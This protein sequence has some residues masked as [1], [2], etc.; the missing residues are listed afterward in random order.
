LAPKWEHRY[1]IEVMNTRKRVGVLGATGSVGQRMVQLLDGHPLFE[2]VAVAASER[3]VGQ[4]FGDA[5]SWRLPSPI[6]EDAAALTVVAC[7]PDL[8]CDLIFSALD[9]SVA[10]PIEE[11]FA[12]TGY[13]VISNAS[14]HRFG[15]HVP[16]V[17][18]EV[19]AEQLS[20]V[21]KQPW[22]GGIITNPNCV[23]IGLAL[24]LKPLV[25]F[26]LEKVHVTTLQAASGAGYPGVPS[27]DLIDN[28]VP[29]I[30]GEAEKIERELPKVL[31]YSPVISAQ[32]H[33]VPVR[34]G[35]LMSVSVELRTASLADL[36]RAWSEFPG[37]EAPLA[38]K[39]PIHVLE[40]I[41]APQPMLHRD[42]EGGMAIAV[43]QVRECPV[44]THRFSVL[45]H[46]T[47][48]GAAGGTL[49]LGALATRFAPSFERL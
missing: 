39:H 3:S 1:S 19:N 35:H 43:G 9:A 18:P 2:L 6:P 5:V 27:M 22:E 24:A 40:G 8:D 13:L 12:R 46:N 36:K 49:L 37:V 16:L 38:P 45:S 17:V 34:E 20:W 7:N 10:G 11:A 47:I 33:R 29:W 23:V 21:E 14:S 4:R 32:C 28:V 30:S 26:G 48:R 41:A 31:G 25:P 15:E 44:L 42:L